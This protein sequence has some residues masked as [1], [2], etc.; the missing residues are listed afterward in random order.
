MCTFDVRRD[1]HTKSS[2][3]EDRLKAAEQALDEEQMEELSAAPQEKIEDEPEE[4]AAVESEDEQDEETEY[5][6]EKVN[7]GEDKKG[8]ESCAFGTVATV[9]SVGI[10]AF[11][12]GRFLK[13]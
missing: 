5:V 11:L 7:D 9:G 2:Q 12:V 8:R 4:M 6:V 13:W 3:V 10:M 1:F